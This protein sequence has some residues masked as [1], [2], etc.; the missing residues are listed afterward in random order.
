MSSTYTLDFKRYSKRGISDLTTCTV[1]RPM[2]TQAYN[3]MADAPWLEL[4][5]DSADLPPHTFNQSGFQDRYD[6]ARFAGDYSTGKQKAYAC[7]VCYTVQIPADALAGTVAK[8]ESIAAT[9]YGDRWTAQGAVLSAILSSSATPPSWADVLAATYT[10][11]DPVTAADDVDPT[12]QAPLRKLTRSND[13]HDTLCEASLPLASGVDATAYLHVCLRLGDYIALPQVAIEGGGTRDSAWVE[14]GALLFGDTLSVTFDRDVEADGPATLKF[15]ALNAGRASINPFNSCMDFD[16]HAYVPDSDAS[17]SATLNSVMFYRHM[18]ST[19]SLSLAFH[20]SALPDKKMSYLA[21]STHKTA[22][23]VFT[24]GTTYRNAVHM[25]VYGRTAITN[26][27]IVSGISFAQAIPAPTAGLVFRLSLYGSLADRSTVMSDGTTPMT[28][29][30]GLLAP[31]GVLSAA[32]REGF[33]TALPMAT[34]YGSTLTNMSFALTNTAY[35]HPITPLG[36]IDLTAELAAGA[37]VPFSAPYTLP[38]FA[39]IFAVLSPIYVT[40]AFAGAINTS[41]SVAWLPTDFY[42]H[43]A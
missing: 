5:E 37:V 22:G 40:D 7:A 12:W 34:F 41:Y 2:V 3:R 28:G 26:G 31:E 20:K 14:G 10:S 18:I 24:D 4:A 43:L 6:A 39:C 17:F 1:L 21:S 15:A 13:G 25:L 29:I 36:Y 27:E 35:N 30:P 19:L 42:L 38:A 16:S 11:P 32:L 9:L 8:I 33:A 23:F